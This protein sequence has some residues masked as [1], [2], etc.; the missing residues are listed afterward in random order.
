MLSNEIHKSILSDLYHFSPK[1]H[2]KSENAQCQWKLVYRITYVKCS[3]MIIHK[4][5]HEKS[6]TWKKVKMINFNESGFIKLGTSNAIEWEYISP[7]RLWI[8]SDLYYFILKILEKIEHYHYQW[9][10][11]YRIKHVKCYR[12]RIH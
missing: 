12:M 6:I 5:W 3:G 4:S 11:V 8:L 7:D 10:W 2:E 1:I 9:K